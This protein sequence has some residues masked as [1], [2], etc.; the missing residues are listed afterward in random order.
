MD[1]ELPRTETFKWGEQPI[2]FSPP[3][4]SWIRR[5]HRPRGRS[6]QAGYYNGARWTSP[7]TDG[8]SIFV[9]ELDL[10]GKRDRCTELEAVLEGMDRGLT[11]EGFGELT[12]KAF[13]EASPPLND[14]EQYL[15]DQVNASIERAREAFVD[16]D[17]DRAR[18]DIQIARDQ[19]GRIRYSLDDVI[20]LVM[21]SPDGFAVFRE[22]I[23]AL[24]PVSIEVA[25]E[26]AVQKDY[27]KRGEEGEDIYGREIYVLHNN[28]LFVAGFLGQQHNLALFERIVDTFFFPAGDCEH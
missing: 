23:H 14:Q 8:D 16:Q 20:D 21:F 28:R 13:C 5:E 19:A 25:G 26:P 10:P 2:S 9:V 15:A 11:R 12:R 27:T 17:L 22:G 3:P 4:D 24:D 6:S 7:F 18:R 1:L